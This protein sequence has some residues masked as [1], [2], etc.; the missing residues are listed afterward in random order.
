[1]I[2]SK[3]VFSQIF[4]RFRGALISLYLITQQL[5]PDTMQTNALQNDEQNNESGAEIFK[6]FDRCH[7]LIS[8]DESFVVIYYTLTFE[9]KSFV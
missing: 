4:S 6:L 3:S 1:M 8:N 5:S 2:G 9:K 7:T